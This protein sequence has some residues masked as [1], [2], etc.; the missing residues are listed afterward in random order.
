MTAEEITFNMEELAIARV[1]IRELGDRLA[2]AEKTHI[3]IRNET[4]DEV[5]RE[6]ERLTIAFGVDTV[7]SFMVLIKDMKK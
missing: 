1:A 3:Q 2:T 4:L 7:H 6:L 5:A